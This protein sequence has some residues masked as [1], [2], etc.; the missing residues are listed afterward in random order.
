MSACFMHAADQQTGKGA[1]VEPA[2]AVSFCGRQ[3]QVPELADGQR[4]ATCHEHV[5]TRQC[6]CVSRFK[7]GI[8]EVV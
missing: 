8:G 6:L 7:S 2:T 4:T 5:I 3:R 1:H